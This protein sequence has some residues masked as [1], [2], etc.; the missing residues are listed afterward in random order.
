MGRC[1]PTGRAHL[2]RGVKFVYIYDLGDEWEHE[3][4]VTAATD[5]PLN[6]QDDVLAYLH[7]G[8]RAAPPEDCGGAP[9]YARLLAALKGEPGDDDAANV[10]ESLG[11]DFDPELFDRRATSHALMLATAGCDLTF[12]GANGR[13]KEARCARLVLIRP[14]LNLGVT[15]Q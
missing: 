15:Q 9:G 1:H 10:R 7:D 6:E 3:I 13:S 8:R 2:N 5:I 4:E 12:V 14:Q 11:G